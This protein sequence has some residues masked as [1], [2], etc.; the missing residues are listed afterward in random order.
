MLNVPIILSLLLMLLCVE[1]TSKSNQLASGDSFFSS[2]MSSTV[3]AFGLDSEGGRIELEREVRRESAIR[4]GSERIRE[5]LL[6]TAIECSSLAAPALNEQVVNR[7][8]EKELASDPE[9]VAL[10]WLQMTERYDFAG[11]ASPESVPSALRPC[12]AASIVKA[13]IDL[14]DALEREHDKISEIIRKG[15]PPEY[16]P[17]GGLPAGT[18]PSLIKDADA[19]DAYEAE[20]RAREEFYTA[21]EKVNSINTAASY[22]IDSSGHHM[23][24]FVESLD[25]AA[26][27][28]VRRLAIKP[29][30]RGRFSGKILQDKRSKPPEDDPVPEFK[31]P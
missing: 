6:L 7:W 30:H 24:K 14:L 15:P 13:L 27:D 20:I 9:L 22:L 26:Q 4:A 12:L 3:D 19:R 29:G 17:P 28:L 25:P 2:E 8:W 18:S 10:A 31:A 1:E 16:G 5:Y 23:L 11:L 21:K